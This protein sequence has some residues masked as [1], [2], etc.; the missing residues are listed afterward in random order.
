MQFNG[1]CGDHFETALTAAAA[2]V[3]AC[4]HPFQNLMSDVS[5]QVHPALQLM[6]AKVLAK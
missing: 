5:I 1:E 3:K 4:H 6:E 2:K